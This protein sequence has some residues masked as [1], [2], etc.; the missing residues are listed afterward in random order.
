ML[1]NQ[2]TNI[3]RTSVTTGDGEYSFT[4]LDPGTYAVTVTY[5]GFKKSE[6]RNIVVETG[7]TSTVDLSMTL[8]GS[9]E[10]VEVS[11]AEPLIDTA[12][13]NGGQGFRRSN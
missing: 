13:A 11:T 6:N 3:V 9:T 5:T 1:T 4:S 10:T 8:G 2:E 7:A 12:N